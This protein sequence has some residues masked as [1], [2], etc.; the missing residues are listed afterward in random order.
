MHGR[1]INNLKY[2]GSKSRHAK[3]ILPIILKDKKENQYYVEPFVGG[4]NVI[5]HVSGLRI[6]SDVNKALI[7]TLD[8]ASKGWIPPRYFT[9]QEYKDVKKINNENDPLTEYAAFALSYGGKY[10]GGWCRD[11]AGKRNYVEEAYRNAVK[12]FPKLIDA[13][14]ICSQYDELKIPDDSIIYCDPPYESTT[15]Y[16]NSN[17]DHA[18][19]WSW[20]LEK[21]KTNKVFVSEYSAP[22]EWESVWEKEVNSSLTKNT[23][24]KKAT[25]KLFTL[26]K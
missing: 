6:G 15:N 1:L 17:F 20:C 8:Y 2:M 13:N 22:I 10:F 25:E 23:G 21:S 26:R 19:F 4:A 11:S 7:T 3:Y 14:F 9:E 16:K 18:K 12:Q 24:S 5:E